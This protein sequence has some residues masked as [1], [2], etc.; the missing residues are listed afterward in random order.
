VSED[1]AR[2]ASSDFLAEE[3]RSRGWQVQAPKTAL[4]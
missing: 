3:L 2:Q 1:M 4:G